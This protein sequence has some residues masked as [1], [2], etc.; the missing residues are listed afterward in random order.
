M[1]L[2]LSENK[3]IGFAAQAVRCKISSGETPMQKTPFFPTTK[4]V[5]ARDVSSR[6]RII[7]RDA[8]VQER[9]AAQGLGLGEKE[10]S[11]IKN[12][13]TGYY[14]RENIAPLERL[15]YVVDFAKSTLTKKGVKKWLLEPNP[16]LNNVSPVL[17]LRSDEELE[18]A[19]S[20]LAALGHG[21]PA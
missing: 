16:Y 12:K 6:I 19:I 9:S 21:F 2:N 14:R 11:R 20:L 4:K 8:G 15:A 13:R 10:F 1:P 7:L 17:C 3:G 5:K 18:K